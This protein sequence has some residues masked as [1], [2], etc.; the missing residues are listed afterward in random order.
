MA[1]KED[2]L[3]NSALKIMLFF[4]ER[5]SAE[6]MQGR[7]HAHFQIPWALSFKTINKLYNR[8]NNDRS[9]LE[10][11]HRGLHLCVLRRTLTLSEW[12]CKQTSVNQQVRLQHN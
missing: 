3:Q 9:V 7:F 5:R 2:C 12:R 4:T 8:L 10:K 1:D 11:K 6:A